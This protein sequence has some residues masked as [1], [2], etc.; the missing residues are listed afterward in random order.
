M[1]IFN[2]L[3]TKKGSA[4]VEEITAVKLC[5]PFTTDLRDNSIYDVPITNSGVTLGSDGAVVNSSNTISIG[6]T[7]YNYTGEFTFEAIINA[8][9]ISEYNY[10]FTNSVT[11]SF[12][13][14]FIRSTKTI[15]VISYATEDFQFD[16]TPYFEKET[17]IAVVCSSQFIRLYINGELKKEYPRF[18]GMFL[19]MNGATIGNNINDQQLSAIIGGIKITYRALEPSQFSLTR[20]FEP[21]L[22]DFKVGTRTYI[23]DNGLWNPSFQKQVSAGVIFE[24]DRIKIPQGNNLDISTGDFSGKTIVMEFFATLIAGGISNGSLCY[25]SLIDSSSVV[26]KVVYN[27]TSNNESVNVVRTMGIKYSDGLPKTRIKSENNQLIYIS[28]IWIED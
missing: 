5:F 18:S 21:V 14:T 2:N 17:S 6:G 23:Y 22:P 1:P 20:P 25:I 16:Y 13:V 19:R 4:N 28:R 27:L 24:Q 12:G 26:R 10:F 9:L 8:K 3:P 11:K 7:P 15:R